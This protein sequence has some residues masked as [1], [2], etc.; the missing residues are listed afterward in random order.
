M[1]GGKNLEPVE[2]VPGSGI[3]EPAA[4]ESSF[5]AS[6]VKALRS[7]TA[8]SVLAAIGLFGTVVSARLWMISSWA[9]DVPFWDQWEAEGTQVLV[10]WQQGTLHAGNLLAAHNEHRVAL[11][12]ITA[13]A[14]TALV[15]VWDPRVEMV[16]NAVFFAATVTVVWWWLRERFNTPRQLSI[17]TLAL[18]IVTAVPYSWQ[19]TINGFHSQQ[20][21]LIALSIFGIN[22]A[23]RHP[24]P[25][26]GWWLGVVCLALD[27]FTMGSGFAAAAAVLVTLPLIERPLRRLMRNHWPTLVACAIIVV[28][29]ALLR[30]DF[31]PHRPLKASSLVEFLHALFRLMEWPQQGFPPF[32]VLSYLPLAL[33]TW[34]AWRTGTKDSRFSWDPVVIA[35][36]IWTVAQLIATAYARGAGAPLPAPRYLDSLNVG[37][38]LNFIAGLVLLKRWRETRLPRLGVQLLFA[39]WCL[40]ACVGFSNQANELLRNTAYPIR[41]WFQE[42]TTNL[43]HY[44]STRDRTWLQNRSI[45]FPND[46]L[47]V[48]Y[49]NIPELR[50]LLPV[51]VRDAL[52]VTADTSEGFSE[53]HLDNHAPAFSYG[54]FWTSAPETAGR[55]V[56]HPLD[57]PAGGYLR[58]EVA[59][60]ATAPSAVSLELW[61]ADLRTRLESIA[62]PTLS[63][64]SPASVYVRR[65]GEPFRIVATASGAGSWLAFS[66]PATMPVLSYFCLWLADQGRILLVFSFGL[67]ALVCIIAILARRNPMPD[68]RPGSPKSAPA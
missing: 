42:M 36:G 3:H 62:L 51:S 4:L 68:P 45:P 9:S 46:Q 28:A 48:E 61:S 53:E 35:A 22:L 20:F 30:V 60:Q 38:F 44:M 54:T 17:V 19:N 65:P 39:A 1:A 14:L 52:P 15:G 25:S 43:A 40:C 33:L 49:T 26:G 18:A 21:Y 34:D 2:G 8:F 6:P 37:V 10:P 5:P 66:R 11:T 16:F 56:S 7:A 58:F 32:V 63:T 13:L 23:L 64:Q 12:R 27:I 31:P 67:L 47:L 24:A 57:P 59:G 41:S 50:A 29:G 55:W